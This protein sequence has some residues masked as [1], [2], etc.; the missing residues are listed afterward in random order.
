VGYDAGVDRWFL[1]R[2]RWERILMLVLSVWAIFALIMYATDYE[3]KWGI[4][5]VVGPGFSVFVYFFARFAALAFRRA[6]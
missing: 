3:P 5:F 2:P 6:E 1:S 4:A